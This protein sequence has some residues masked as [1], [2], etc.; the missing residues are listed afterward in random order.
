MNDIIAYYN[1]FN[2]WGRLDREP[3]EYQVNL[4][5]I[6]NNL[7]ARGRVLDNG[8]GPGKYAMA[9]AKLGCRVTLTDLTPRLV[10]LARQ[11]A[12]ELELTQQFDGFYPADARDL[13]QFPDAHF[14]ASLMLGP[15]Y[16][17]QEEADR[18]RAV[19]ELLRVT[20]PGGRVFVA[21]MSRTRFLATSLLFPE[22]WKPNHTAQG[23]RG[24]LETGVFNHADPGRF[25]G[26]YYFDIDAI[27]PFMEAHGFHTEKLIGSGSIAG[28][29]GPEQWAYWRQRGGE[30]YDAI[31]Q[32]VM[33]ESENP[34]ILGHS[35]HLLYIGRRA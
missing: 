20:K 17:L 7:P 5:H 26:A 3:L 11:K 22:A 4:H 21:F 33:K 14:D 12:Q 32:L 31:M 30:E 19:S 13:S 16:H 24:F 8:A 10:E 15:L 6:A 23:I 29:L 1:P 34:H 35:S 9:P 18:E 25:T 2:E 28:A 27:K